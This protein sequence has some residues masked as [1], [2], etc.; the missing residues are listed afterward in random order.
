MLIIR[1]ISS[2][3]GKSH[4]TRK[5]NIQDIFTNLNADE[6]EFIMSGITKQE[7]TDAFGK[8]EA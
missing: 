8:G 1:N 3:S 7:C 6:R 5:E 4:A 2:L